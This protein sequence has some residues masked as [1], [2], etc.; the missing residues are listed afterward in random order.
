MSEI[1]T[2]S[3]EYY[4]AV[5]FVQAVAEDGKLS[6]EEAAAVEEALGGFLE[7]AESEYEAIDL[8]NYIAEEISENIDSYLESMK[9]A[10]EFFSEQKKEVRSGILELMEDLAGADGVSAK[11]KKFF[12]GLKSAWK[13]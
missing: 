1:D 9:G 6:Q 10:I 4:A 3:M 7:G 5:L 2:S 12:Q 13:V 8:L 11:E